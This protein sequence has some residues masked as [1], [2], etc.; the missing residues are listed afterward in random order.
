VVV[1]GMNTLGRHLVEALSARGERVLAVDT[2][3]AKLDGLDVDVLQGNVD[4]HAV[5]HEAGIPR[6]R[7][8]VSAL[9]IEDANTLL[10]WR[11]RH[12]GVPVSVHAFDTS[13]RGDLERLGVDHIMDS[14]REGARRLRDALVELEILD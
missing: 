8:V 7:L 12:L 2:D 3:P 13:V 1:I 4:H 5:L 6:A 10:A 14:K 9:Q 11:C